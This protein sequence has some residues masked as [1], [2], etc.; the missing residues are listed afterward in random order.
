MAFERTAA[1]HRPMVAL[2]FLLCARLLAQSSRQS[3]GESGFACCRAACCLSFLA[4]KIVAQT[5]PVPMA[6]KIE[7]TA[8]PTSG[9][10]RTLAGSP[11]RIAPAA[12]MPQP[13]NITPKIMAKAVPDLETEAT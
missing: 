6:M 5:M 10:P 2:R 1:I 12:I 11:N 13:A 4:P 9:L 7:Q 3:Q 8:T